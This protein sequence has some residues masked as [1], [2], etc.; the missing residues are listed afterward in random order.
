MLLIPD[1]HRHTAAFIC[2]LLHAI[3]SSGFIHGCCLAVL[4]LVDK[5][6]VQQLWMLSEKK[7]VVM[8]NLGFTF[9]TVQTLPWL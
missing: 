4:T 5:A 3:H 7:V 8:S 6:A 1:C 9:C 2:C